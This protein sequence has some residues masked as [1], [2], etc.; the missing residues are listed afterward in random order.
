MT[1]TINGNYIN[2]ATWRKNGKRVNTPVWFAEG[3]TK[4][5]YYL[6][7]SGEAGKV[8]RI[9]NSNYAEI[10][11]CDVTGKLQ[12]PWLSV[13]A[14]LLERKADIDKA[15]KAIAAKYGWQSRMIDFFSAMARKKQKRCYIM[16][17]V[18]KNQTNGS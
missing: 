14:S 17:Q 8:K 12:G 2:L 16:L 18:D 10:A 13:H 4:G 5:I 11:P 3:D 7:S 6:F 1:A 9:R 15:K